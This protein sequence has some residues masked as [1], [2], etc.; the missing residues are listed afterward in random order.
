M[1]PARLALAHA[2]VLALSSPGPARAADA[3]RALHLAGWT[4]LGV[5]ALSFAGAGLARTGHAASFAALPS[6]WLM[7][8]GL[9]STGGGLGLLWQGSSA[10]RL[11]DVANVR[12]PGLDL[13]AGLDPRR[14]S[15]LGLRLPVWRMRF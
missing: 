5:G 1:S 7:A 2:L 11:P 10:A 13:A 14:G 15:D 12:P 4:L 8:T 6:T 3:R 9:A